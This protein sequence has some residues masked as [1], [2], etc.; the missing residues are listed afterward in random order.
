MKIHQKLS[1]KLISTLYII[2]RLSKNAPLKLFLLIFSSIRLIF[3]KTSYFLQS[4]IIYIGIVII[5]IVCVAQF[6]KYNLA[7][8]SGN[9]GI[10]QGQ[11]IKVYDGDTITIKSTQNKVHRIRLYGLD[12]PE[13]FQDFGKESG[14]YL[15]KLCPINS[16]T[17]IQI[18]DIDKYKR[19]VGI[20][21]CKGVEV[22]SNLVKN[23]YAWAYAEYSLSY[24]PLEM[25]ARIRQL[26]LW[27]QK[28]PIRP[29]TYRKVEKLKHKKD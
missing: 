24:I 19:I 2:A 5:V 20:V 17:T 9:K 1:N 16:K 26:G 11:I 21:Y 12:A 23:G 10:L 6:T 29:S 7:T 13:S 25:Y 14:E 27:K 15:L 28:N 8:I 18:K 4:K 22:N 3:R